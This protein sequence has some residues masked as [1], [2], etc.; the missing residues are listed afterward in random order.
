MRADLYPSHGATMIE[1]V[2]QLLG[3]RFQ[4]PDILCEALT[5]AS[6]ADSRL[7]SNERMEFLGDSILGCVICEYLFLQYPDL[8]E[9]EMTKIKSSVVSRRVCAQISTDIKLADLLNL[10]K[11]MTARAAMPSSVAAAVFE[12]MVAA[13]YLDGG[14]EPA[15]AFVL[16]FMA[17]YVTEAAESAHQHNFKSVLQQFAQKHLPANPQYMLLDEKGPD[18]CK[19]FEVA[20]Q[21]GQRLFDPAWA[22]NKKEAEQKAALLALHALGLATEVNGRI[23]VLE[24]EAAA[25]AVQ[26][27][28]LAPT[29]HENEDVLS[30]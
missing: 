9:G 14:H 1:H 7:R 26:H 29:A 3:Y 5:H 30:F 11:G 21:I 25:Q 13:I 2:E 28:D 16:K 17:P 27:I 24:G 20:V 10:G 15:K 19:A 22:N 4:N 23:T 12:S 6:S 8:L 18:H